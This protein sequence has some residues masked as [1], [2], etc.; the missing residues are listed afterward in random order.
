VASALAQDGRLIAVGEQGDPG[1]S[2]GAAWIAIPDPATPAVGTWREVPT[3][4]APPSSYAGSAVATDTQI[5]AV[6]QSLSDPLMWNTIDGIEW[7]QLP[8]PFTQPGETAGLSSISRLGEMLI[9]SGEDPSGAAIWWSEQ[10]GVWNKA[11]APAAPGGDLDGIAQAGGRLIAYSPPGDPPLLWA[12][13]DGRTWTDLA[14]GQVLDAESHLAGVAEVNGQHVLA[15]GTPADTTQV[16][17]SGDGTTWT[18][19]PDD[20]AFAGLWPTSLVVFGDRI[21]IAGERDT[22]DGWAN[23]VVSSADLAAWDSVVLD[24]D[25]GYSGSSNFGMSVV[26]SLLTVNGFVYDDGIGPIPVLWSTSDLVFWTRATMLPA[27]GSV[28]DQLA[29][30]GQVDDV[31]RFGDRLVAVGWTDRPGGN[32]LATAWTSDNP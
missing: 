2:A 21:V 3:F 16:W 26:G 31:V 5:V 20:P 12:S 6:G 17:V 7:F 30:E 10:L 1:D 29:L 18:R 25:P 15:V 9:A 27:L 13:S 23:A 8:A 11:A 19:L 32:W 14:I 28:N 24:R 4:E 22:G